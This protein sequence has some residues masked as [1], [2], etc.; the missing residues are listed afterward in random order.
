MLFSILHS[1]QS[2]LCSGYAFFRFRLLTFAFCDFL[3]SEK[4]FCSHIWT[5][6][7]KDCIFIYLN[8]AVVPLH[9]FLHRATFISSRALSHSVIQYVSSVRQATFHFCQHKKYKKWKEKKQKKNIRS[10]GTKLK[11]K[12][13]SHRS[14]EIKAFPFKSQMAHKAHTEWERKRNVNTKRDICEW[15]RCSL[16]SLIVTFEANEQQKKYAFLCITSKSLST[17]ADYARATCTVFYSLEWAMGASSDDSFRM[18]DA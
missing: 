13:A 1:N 2:P 8:N 18:H 6:R 16:L 3:A 4:R 14:H 5:A 9:S 7:R 10:A 15:M 17:L 12:K 11:L